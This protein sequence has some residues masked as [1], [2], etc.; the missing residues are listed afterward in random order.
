[1]QKVGKPLVFNGSLR[2]CRLKERFSQSSGAVGAGTPP[3]AQELSIDSKCAPEVGIAHSPR[4][5]ER[6]NYVT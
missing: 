6:A 3:D 4:E 1:M 5:K 2:V